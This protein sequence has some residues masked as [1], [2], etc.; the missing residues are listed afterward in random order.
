MRTEALRHKPR[1]L[2]RDPQILSQ[3]RA[4]DALFVGRDEP[5]R[6]EPN[7]QFNLAV[8]KDRSNLDRETLA[9]IGAFVCP[10]I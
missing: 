7:A 2:L 4:G 9:A 3:C 10:L 1:C 5:D 6:H 8:F